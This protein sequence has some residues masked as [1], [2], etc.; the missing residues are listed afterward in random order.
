MLAPTA[1]RETFEVDVVASKLVGVCVTTEAFVPSVT[2][3]CAVA[4]VSVSSE[5]AV[6]ELDAVAPNTGLPVEVAVT[7]P[8]E[9]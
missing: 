5:K 8:V 3:V 9:P 7:G 4:G 2:M 6:D 1:P